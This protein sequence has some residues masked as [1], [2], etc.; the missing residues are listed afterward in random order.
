MTLDDK[1]ID[2]AIAILNRIGSMDK[3]DLF[4]T[5]PG[6]TAAIYKKAVSAG[7]IKADKDVTDLVGATWQGRKRIG[8]ES[9]RIKATARTIVGGSD[10]LYD[11][12]EL[13]PYAGRPGSEA[14]LLLPS[15]CA[16]G[17]H[18]PDGRFVPDGAGR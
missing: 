8:L 4:N 14:A 16:D 10:D 15:R 5:V 18:Y 9:S 17:L 1:I 11:G 3:A 12:A 2:D 6:L 7:Y 13:M